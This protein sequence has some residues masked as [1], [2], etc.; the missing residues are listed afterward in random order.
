MIFLLIWLSGVF[1]VSWVVAS[2]A[3]KLDRPFYHAIIFD[4][5][6]WMIPRMLAGLIWPLG[7]AVALVI[8]PAWVSYRLATN[9]NKPQLPK[10]K[11]VK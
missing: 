6:D 11:V 5:T 9:R 7:L 10:V 2:K 4:K 1:A 3:A 8:S